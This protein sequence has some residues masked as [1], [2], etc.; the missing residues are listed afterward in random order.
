MEAAYPEE[1]HEDFAGQFGGIA[2]VIL[3]IDRPIMM[4]SAHLTL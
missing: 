3:P 2:G 4:L 1:L